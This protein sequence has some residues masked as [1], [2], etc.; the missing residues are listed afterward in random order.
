MLELVL[1]MGEGDDNED[2][3][4]SLEAA[5][6]QKE[7]E[8]QKKMDA[9]LSGKPKKKHPSFWKNCADYFSEYCNYTSIH[10]FKY[11][12]EQKRSIFEK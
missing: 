11:L 1:N 4:S 2:K 12:G 7:I 5:I 3:M 10:G 6:Y 9:K 8:D